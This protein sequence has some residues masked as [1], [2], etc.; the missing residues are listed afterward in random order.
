MVNS[1][2]SAAEERVKT[3]G[4]RVWIASQ[5]AE[6]K[7]RQRIRKKAGLSEQVA[8]LR[9]RVETLEGLARVNELLGRASLDLV[10]ATDEER[11]AHAALRENG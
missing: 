11:A 2:D 5:A 4:K 1:K 10:A 6:R 8:D 7:R 3:P 9:G